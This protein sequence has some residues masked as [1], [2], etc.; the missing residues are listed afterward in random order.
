LSSKL[1][2]S[3]E[4]EEKMIESICKM[5]YDTGTFSA[6]GIMNVSTRSSFSWCEPQ[7]R[8]SRA[9]CCVAIEKPPERPDPASYSQEEKL[10]L[11]Q[12][13]TWNSPDITTNEWSPFRLRQ[14]AEVKVRNLSATASAANALIHFY[15]SQ[16]G[17]G[18]NRV[19]LSSAMV[20]LSPLQERTIL[21]PFSQAVLGG[22]PTIGVYTK[23]EHSSDIKLINNTGG[24]VHHGVM[25][26]E[27]GRNFTFQFPVVNAQGAANQVTLSVMPNDL[28]GSVSPSTR[29]CSP[30]EQ[31]MATLTFH[32]PNTIHGTPGAYVEKEVTVLGRFGNG[33]LIG[34]VTYVVRIDD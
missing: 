20:S 7:R 5:E 16:F 12:I 33:S 15:V 14:E 28:S 21:F 6:R 9:S 31:F 17:I 26:S 8:K 24:Q 1:I 18:M 10:A 27:S 30:W 19:A 29:N 34:G 32:V 11:G 2:K 23:I 4:N 22:S 25:T 3:L 13:P